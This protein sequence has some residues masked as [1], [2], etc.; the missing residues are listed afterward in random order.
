MRRAL[1][2]VILAVGG[3]LIVLVTLVT[4]DDR[5]RLR[6]TGTVSATP[7][8]GMAT[9]TRVSATVGSMLGTGRDRAL[10]NGS[11]TLLVVVSAVLVVYML[12][13]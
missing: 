5:V 1:K 2:N 6:L 7:A 3:V 12:R 8:E 9:V 11:L 4:V 10:S 13:L